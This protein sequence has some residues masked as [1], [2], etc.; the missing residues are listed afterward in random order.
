M[1]AR[2]IRVSTLNQ[3]IERQL[4][5]QYKAQILYI[6][7]IIGTVPFTNCPEGI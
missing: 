2:Y 3:N 1:K 6:D 4:A 7:K 5:K